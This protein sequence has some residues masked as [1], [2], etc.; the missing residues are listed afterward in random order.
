MAKKTRLDLKDKRFGKLKVVNYAGND[1]KGYS[2]WKCKCDCGN[3]SIVRGINLT[4]GSTRSC[5]CSRYAFTINDGR[6]NPHQ[7]VAGDTF[8]KLT[9]VSLE[10]KDND[11]HKYYYCMC[12]CGGDTI[13]REDNLKFGRTKSCGCMKGGNKSEDEW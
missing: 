1:S 4:Q 13:V 10:M 8:G 5:G 7:L 3:E 9:V 11:R 12:E 2:T 6:P